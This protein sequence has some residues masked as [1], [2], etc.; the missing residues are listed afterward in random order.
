MQ[1]GAIGFCMGG[2]LSLAAA[3]HADI[4]CAVPFYGLPGEAICQPQNIKIP[5]AM[6]FGRLDTLT[7]FSDAEVGDSGECCLGSSGCSWT[8]PNDETIMQVQDASSILALASAAQETTGFSCCLSYSLLFK[9]FPSVLMQS[10]IAFADKVNTAGGK[11]DLHIYEDAGHGFLNEG[12]EGVAKREHMGFP[13]PP[14]ATQQMAW[15]RVIE[16]LNQHLKQWNIGEGGGDDG[17]DDVKMSL[18]QI[19]QRLQLY[20]SHI[21][22]CSRLKIEYK[23][24]FHENT[25]ATGKLSTTNAPPLHLPFLPGSSTAQ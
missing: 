14:A 11:A 20:G 1:V 17:L 16:F 24:N 12:Q 8:T 21:L 18:H 13:H 4:Q 3:Q 6:H 9:L 5:I 7:G 19:Y 10:A 2:A 23:Q 22:L 25:K 15:Q